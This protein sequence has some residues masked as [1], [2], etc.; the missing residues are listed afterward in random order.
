MIIA[1]T[2][3]DK[4]L[5]TEENEVPVLVIENR[6]FLQSLL[7]LLC[8]ESYQCDVDF[9]IFIN[10]NEINYKKDLETIINFFDLD[11]N[12]SKN[13]TKLYSY[14]RSEHINEMNYLQSIDLSS[15]ILEFMDTIINDCDF[16][17]SCNDEVEFESIFKAMNLKFHY[18]ETSL[19]EKLI[20]YTKI[21]RDFLKVKVFILFNFKTLFSIEE[22]QQ[23]YTFASY[24]KIELIFIESTM[25]ENR[26]PN[27]KYRIIDEDLCVIY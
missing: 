15:H 14:I 13:L 1:S 7:M 27:E 18:E 19:L 8:D 4:S 11:I 20:D 26:L 21:S 25:A 6:H 10:N 2:I 12:K 23:F 16:N 9:S 22:Q 24:N 3:F 5:I 17:L